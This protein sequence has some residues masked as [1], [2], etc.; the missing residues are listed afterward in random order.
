MDIATNLAIRFTFG[1][2]LPCEQRPFKNSCF[3][4]LILNSKLPVYLKMDQSLGLYPRDK[5]KD[6]VLCENT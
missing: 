6:S 2:D 5:L 1:N 4:S 3:V